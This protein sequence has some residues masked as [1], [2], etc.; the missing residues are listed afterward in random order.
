MGG[1]RPESTRIDWTRLESIVVRIGSRTGEVEGKNGYSIL[2][3]MAGAGRDDAGEAEEWPACCLLS[4]SL[5]FPFVMLHYTVGR[6]F[7]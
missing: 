6:G 4:Q 7:Q 3:P 1:F 5:T 2:R